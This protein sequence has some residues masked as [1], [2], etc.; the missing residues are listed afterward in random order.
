MPYRIIFYLLLLVLAL[1][2][3]C[4]TNQTVKNT[5]KGTKNFWYTYMNVP[6]SIDYD[7]TGKMPEYETHF[8][9]A[10]MGI[11]VQ[12]LALER[13]MQNADKPP[14][15]EWLNA[16]FTQ[17][18]WVDGI[19]GL[20]SEGGIVG[21]AGRF[22][23]SFDFDQLLAPDPKQHLHALKGDVQGSEVLLAVPLH[24]GPDFLGLVV[25]Y[26]EMRSLMHYSDDPER[27]IV[28]SPDGLLWS[29]PSSGSLPQADWKAIVRSS[30][31]GT[32]S[33]ASGSYQ[34][35]SRFLGNYPLVFA[36]QKTASGRKTTAQTAPQE[37]S[38]YADEPP[39]PGFFEMS[40]YFDEEDY[41][42]KLP[43]L[44]TL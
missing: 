30:T 7:D 42:L 32:I 18:P 37:A 14:S 25:A 28:T 15:S 5:W 40:P 1:H 29:G 11:D 19:I 8:S 24:D 6:A 3:G 44:P 17:F 23:K 21:Q 22:M 43:T 12:L 41:E 31:S 36:V 4:S 10:M 9:R 2:T 34:W 16:F 35:V 20:N 38:F 26:F 27:L 39:P 33:D 13:M